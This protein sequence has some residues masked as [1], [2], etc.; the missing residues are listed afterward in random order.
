LAFRGS[1][2]RGNLEKEG[3]SYLEGGFSCRKRK[4]KKFLSQ[5]H[6][7]YK[8]PEKISRGGTIGKIP[9]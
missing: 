1:S 6:I 2:K 7:L 4:K 3:G 8:S 9:K 5:Y